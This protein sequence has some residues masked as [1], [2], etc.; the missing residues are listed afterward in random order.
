MLA[1]HR[2]VLMN[3]GLCRARVDKIIDGKR[4]IWWKAH[5]TKNAWK[6]LKLFCARDWCGYELGDTKEEAVAKLWLKL[7][8]S[9]KNT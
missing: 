5:M 3:I 4:V 8:S 1:F 6:R 9:K 7:N 2:R